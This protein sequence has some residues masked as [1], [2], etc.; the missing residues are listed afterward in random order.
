[1]QHVRLGLSP[2]EREAWV[3]EQIDKE[4]DGREVHAQNAQTGVRRIQ[5]AQSA[6]GSGAGPEPGGT[7]ASGNEYVLNF[8]M[9]KGKTVLPRLLPGSCERILTTLRD[10]CNSHLLVG[11]QGSEQARPAPL[12]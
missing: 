7:G 10:W 8:G 9:H 3:Q 5:E 2:E 12:L 4:V 11:R 1:M 6:G